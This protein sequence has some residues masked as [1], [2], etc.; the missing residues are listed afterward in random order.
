MKRILILEDEENLRA[1]Y[2]QILV[3][4]GYEVVLATDG[5][6]ALSILKQKP[7]D[8]AIVDIKLGNANGL[9]YMGEMLN[10]Q[11]NMKIVVNSAYSV[12]KQDLRVWSADAYL[13]KSSNY[14]EL[15]ATVNS[16]LQ[17]GKKPEKD[18]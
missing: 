18:S 12:Y 2:Q 5:E 4:E 8:L 9:D 11:R 7:C 15:V 17:T 13:L 16:L 14:E 1:L 3:D 6:S 10:M